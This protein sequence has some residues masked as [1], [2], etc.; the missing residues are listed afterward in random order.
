MKLSLELLCLG[1]T[2]TRSERRNARGSAVRHLG[3]LLRNAT[4][5]NGLLVMLDLL[6]LTGEFE[7]ILLLSLLDSLQEWRR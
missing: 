2:T 6:L 3:I 1:S 4:V 7:L 5:G